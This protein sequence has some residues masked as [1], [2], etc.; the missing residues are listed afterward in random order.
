MVYYMT[1]FTQKQ[2]WNQL[3][4]SLD[5]ASLRRCPWN[6]QEKQ[7]IAASY[8]AGFM[9]FVFIICRNQPNFKLFP[10][11][12]SLSHTSVIQPL[13]K[14]NAVSTSQKVK[15]FSDHLFKKKKKKTK[16]LLWVPCIFTACQKCR[17]TRVVCCP[18]VS[19]GTSSA[20]PAASCIK[21]P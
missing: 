1:K 21:P 19:C 4:T 7:H 16:R 12:P 9:V 13:W 2:N 8:F 10:K 11:R 6:Q 20:V 14:E 3:K 15:K 5:A 18:L 17:Q